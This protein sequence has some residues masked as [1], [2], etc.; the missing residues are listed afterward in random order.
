M[1]RFRYLIDIIALVAMTFLLDAVVGAFVRAPVSLQT[2]FV[3][4]AIGKMLL[5]GFA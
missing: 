3:F 4:D 5:V 2:G 1:R